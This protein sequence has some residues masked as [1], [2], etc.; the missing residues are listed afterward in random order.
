[1]LILM[2]GICGVYNFATRA[3]ADIK[4]LREAATA[5]A[6]RGPDDEGFHL[7]QDLGLVNR[8]LSIIDLP[9]GHQPLSNEDGSVWIT[10]NGEIYNYREL[11]SRLSRSGHQFHTG[12]DTEVIA[13]LFEEQGPRCVEEL[14]GMFAFALWDCR[15]R[16]LVLARDRLGVKPLFY[17]ISPDGITFASEI[18]ALRCLARAPFETDPQSIYDFFTFRYI[19]SPRTLYRGILKLPPGHYLL[20]DSRGVSVKRY[21]DL[22]AAAQDDVPTEHLARE[23]MECFQES[24]RLRLI[25]DV[26]VGVFLSGGLDSS[27]IVA[28]MAE[29]GAAPIRTFSVGFDEAGYSELPSARRVAEM[30]SAE[31][32]E[33]TVTACDL[34]QELPRLISYRLEPV[35]EPTDVALYLLARLAAKSVKVAL[36]GEGGDELFA[37]YPKYVAENLASWTALLPRPMM[38]ALANWLPY[39]KRRAR[40][41]LEAL[42]IEDEAE[43]SVAWFAA[44]SPR[45]SRELFTRDFLAAVDPAHPAKVFAEAITRDQNRS[46]LKRMM[47]A[48]LQIWLPDNLLLRGDHM[49][50]AASLEERL[51]FLDHRLVELASALPD[52]SLVHRFQRK[53]FLRRMLDGRLPPEALGRRKIGFTVPVGPWFRGPLKSMVGDL[54]LSERALSCEYFNGGAVRRVVN[55]HLRGTRDRRK[56]LWALLNFELWQRQVG[57]R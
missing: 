18:R 15:H 31:H 2:C 30:Y 56:Q 33:I 46:R 13:H 29:L 5:L 10:F 7:D 19:P 8:R 38:R 42:S 6:H 14:R 52:R 51:P 37:G 53:I 34:A 12:S 48:D 26:P 17:R 1:M 16:R 41:A 25:S 4:E 44:F 55:D 3:P 47:Y 27:A 24:V 45:E 40:I 22:P 39:S 35:A 28:V 49:T 11:R 54:L 20:A 50:M 36:A 32:Q 43:R 57:N 23:V 9:G 21:W